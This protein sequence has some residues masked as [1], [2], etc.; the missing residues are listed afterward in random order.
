MTVERDMYDGRT[1]LGV[2]RERGDGSFVAVFGEEV[3]GP[4]DTA[5]QA[6]DAVL[7][8]ARPGGER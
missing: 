3:V 5:R 2:V 6:V 1:F 8:L 4:F 7:E